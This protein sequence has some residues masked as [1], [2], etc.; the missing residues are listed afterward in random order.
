[1]DYEKGQSRGSGGVDA[2]CDTK[3]YHVMWTFELQARLS[4][5][6]DYRHVVVNAV[7]P[8]FVGSNM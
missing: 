4:R 2:Y 7:H 1:M 8:G 3:L 5:S 6:E